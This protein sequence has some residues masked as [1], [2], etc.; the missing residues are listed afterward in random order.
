MLGGAGVAGG[1]AAVPAAQGS[2][3]AEAPRTPPAVSARMDLPVVV[4]GADCSVLGAA[5]VDATGAPAYCAHADNGA[6]VW[7][8]QP[9]R[10]RT[11]PDR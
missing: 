5:A 11:V 3:S 9:D 8:S 10:L 4:V 1:G 2:T 7:A 6:Q